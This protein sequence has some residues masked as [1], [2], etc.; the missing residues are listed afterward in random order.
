MA[1]AALSD[2]RMTDSSLVDS[3]VGTISGAGVEAKPLACPDAEVGSWLERFE[4]IYRDAG[5]DPKK[6]PWA[7]RK[8]CPWLVSW[9]NAEAPAL[10][11]C[12]ARVAVVGCGLGNDAVEMRE[13]G[14]DVVAFDACPTA[15][16]WAKQMHADHADM[17]VV[18]DLLDMPARLRNRFDL[19]VE[20]HTLQALP[21]RHRGSLAMGMASMLSPRGG[22]LVAV[23]RGREPHVPLETLEGPPFAFTVN[24]LTA[25]MEGCGLGAISRVDEFLDDNSPP[26]KRIRGVF[27][28]Q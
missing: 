7:H 28:R 13:R 20:V 22:M 17:F 2:S 3:R 15:I 27:R 21:P 1:S 6:V 4:A 18:A 14:Y 25:L 9:L 16:H 26:V 10:I 8:P 5:G 23:C 11:R 24:E 12:G 19:V